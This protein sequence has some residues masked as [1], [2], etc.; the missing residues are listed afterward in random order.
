MMRLGGLPAVMLAASALSS[1]QPAV[2]ALQL[3]GSIAPP[4]GASQATVLLPPPRP[5]SA[6]A[7]RLTIRGDARELALFN[8]EGDIFGAAVK[9]GDGIELNFVARPEREADR[10]ILAVDFDTPPAVSAAG[11]RIP[12]GGSLSI[13]SVVPGGGEVRAG[14]VVTLRG[15][16]FRPDTRIRFAG[17]PELSVSYISASEI[18]VTAPAAV[19][20][21]GLSITAV[22]PDGSSPEYLSHWRATETGESAD[23]LIARAIPLFSRRT[24]VSAVLAAAPVGRLAP[25]YVLALAL[26]NPGPAS[27]E[28]SVALGTEIRARIVLPPGGRLTREIVELLGGPADGLVKVTSSQP[29]QVLGL[30]GNRRTGTVM[31]IAVAVE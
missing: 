31:P 7:V 12:A 24:A 2:S 26:Q 3:S 4:A 9:T 16:G 21:D 27:A 1:G 6:G 20:M 8:G 15:T 19:G 22:N 30:F 18:Q 13:R 5:S 10:P 14:S 11:P 25:G 17:L 23:P 29:I 28:I